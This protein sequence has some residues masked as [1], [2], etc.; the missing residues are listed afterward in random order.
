MSDIA[1]PLE[2]T[3]APLLQY[4]LYRELAMEASDAENRSNFN[5]PDFFAPR[6]MPGSMTISVT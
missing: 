2:L 5:F 1:Q 3:T 6:P 4:G